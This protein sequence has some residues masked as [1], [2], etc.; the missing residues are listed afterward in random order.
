MAHVHARAWQ[1]AGWPL[2]IL[3][4]AVVVAALTSAR[5]ASAADV[6]CGQVV[7]QSIV[8]S[9]DLQCNGP[10][11][12]ITSPDISIDLN[13]HTISGAGTGEGI[14]VRSTGATVKNGTIR[15]FTHGVRANSL[16]VADLSLQHLILSS[17]GGG[18]RL[19]LSGFVRI[20]DSVIRNNSFDGIELQETD[21]VSVLRNIVTDNGRA[22]IDAIY[23]VDG[24]LYANNAVRRN[25]GDGIVVAR[26]T[27][28]IIDNTVTANGGDGIRVIEGDQNLFSRYFV[29]GNDADRNANYGIAQM[30]GMP[31]PKSNT[32]KHNGN[33]E[34]C[35][36]I[37]CTPN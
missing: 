29:S 15:G 28:T 22:G 2:V 5:G 33:P 24:A 21:Y 17:N 37:T 9:A 25:G 14:S 8:L 7:S 4:G 18:V 34:Q 30:A 31:D 23:S 12:L 1:A 10:G 35:L 20:E 26:S 36:N 13:G 16:P 6:A 27:S 3:V 11:L 19:L 32:A